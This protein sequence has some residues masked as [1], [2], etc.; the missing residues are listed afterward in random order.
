M[1]KTL[2][3][4]MLTVVLVGL[5]SIVEAQSC[6]PT[7]DR[8]IDEQYEENLQKDLEAAQEFHD[9]IRDRPDAFADNVN[10][11]DDGWPDLGLTALL[12]GVDPLIQRIAQPAVRRACKQMRGRLRNAQSGLESRL[13]GAL[14]G[15]DLR[16]PGGSIGDRIGGGI[17]NPGSGVI[18]EIVNPCILEPNLPQCLGELPLGKSSPV[19]QIAPPPASSPFNG[20]IDL[21]AP[22]QPPANPPANPPS[23][24]PGR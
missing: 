17:G 11:V 24:D 6:S 9:G 13:S 19:N 1:Q 3:S 20:L 10:C 2:L 15:A 16:D 12:S 22:R 4:A 23:N 8:L 5:P 14:G 7:A 18:P 21:F